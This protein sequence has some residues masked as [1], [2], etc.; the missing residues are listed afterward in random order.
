MAARLGGGGEQVSRMT[1]SPEP[2]PPNGMTDTSSWEFK[3]YLHLEPS[4][5]DPDRCTRELRMQ[6]VRSTDGGQSWAELAGFARTW[7]R[8]EVAAR[9][10][11][12]CLHTII[13]DPNN[14]NGFY[15]AIRQ[16]ERFAAMMRAFPGNRSSGLRSQ[17][18]PD[19]TGGVG[20]AC[21]HVAMQ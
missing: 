20:T 17:Y 9:S 5:D 11:G 1:A 16:P 10:C 14:P 2:T 12:M 18:I 15:I 7:F 3:A 21:I 19:P 6:P 8:A 13:L 4:L